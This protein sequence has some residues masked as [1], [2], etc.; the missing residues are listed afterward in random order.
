[1]Q[2]HSYTTFMPQSSIQLQKRLPYLLFT[3]NLNLLWICPVFLSNSIFTMLTCVQENHNCTHHGGWNP[4]STIIPKS[5][6]TKHM[7]FSRFHLIEHWWIYK[8]NL[9]KFITF[10]LLII[11]L[12]IKK[13]LK[14]EPLIY[15]LTYLDAMVIYITLL[16]IHFIYIPYSF[17]EIY[18]SVIYF[19][20][21]KVLLGVHGYK[22]IF[23]L[24]ICC[25]VCQSIVL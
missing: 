6:S 13:Y 23:L 16:H 20:R 7:W 14:H 15:L 22:C 8:L 25:L 24:E 9:I 10:Q 2:P 3:C 21:I 4:L 12:D 11:N 17:Q 18:T 5:K 19:E 1:M